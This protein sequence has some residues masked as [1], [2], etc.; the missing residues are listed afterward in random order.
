MQ[1]IKQK[2]NQNQ[3]CK[4]INFLQVLQYV[5]LKEEKIAMLKNQVV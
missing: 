3:L 1:K 2:L 4:K 5:V